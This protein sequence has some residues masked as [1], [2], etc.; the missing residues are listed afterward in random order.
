MQTYTTSNQQLDLKKLINE[1]RNEPIIL[2]NNSG[3]SFLL[4]PFSENKMNDIFLMLYKSFKDL[5]SPV[6]ENSQKQKKR[7]MTG[8]E[9]IEKWSGTLNESDLENWKKDRYNYLMDKHK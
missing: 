2:K 9:F 7:K 6:F 1:Q 8:K 3:N 4:M 5:N